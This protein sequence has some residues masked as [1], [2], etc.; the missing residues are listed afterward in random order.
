M[1]PFNIIDRGLQGNL[2]NIAVGR[3]CS[4]ATSTR[5][6]RKGRLLNSKG[7]EGITCLVD[8]MVDGY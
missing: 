4:I 3:D 7:A 2:I 8:D 5:Q 1:V 6:D